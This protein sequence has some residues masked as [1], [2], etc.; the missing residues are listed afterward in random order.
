MPQ[1]TMASA[2][3]QPE[4]LE[5]GPA[6]GVERGRQALLL[7]LA[8]LTGIAWLLTLRHGHLPM[9]A[10]HDGGEH[11]VNGLGWQEI[12]RLAAFGMAS[13]GISLSGL[14]SFVIAWAVMM[15]AM[16]FPG[17]SPMLV[18]MHAI[19]WH[20]GGG[21][22]ALRTTAVFVTGYLLVWTTVGLLL[23]TFVRLAG[24]TTSLVALGDRA[25]WAPLVLGATLIVAGLYQFTPF[26]QACLDHC[27]SPFIVIMQRWRD[28]DGGALRMGLGHGLYCLGCCWALFTVLVTAGIMSLA[29]MLALTLV[30]FA[31]KTLPTGRRAV[32][33][34]GV[35]LLILGVAVVT[36]MIPLPLSLE[37]GEPCV[38]LGAGT[39]PRTTVR[40]CTSR[41][42][43]EPS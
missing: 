20:R 41:Q 17:L 36:R 32:P 35:A 28:G 19:A 33:G 12:S 42:W 4:A 23:W 6:A 43:H 10:L 15:A 1:T 5:S 14:A 25:R 11:H 29:W 38:R 3:I 21:R 40:D 2:L 34:I 37:R 22:G 39:T 18:T 7:A 31:E 13:T 8:A 9:G 16:M 24:Q 30:D 27:R 26:K